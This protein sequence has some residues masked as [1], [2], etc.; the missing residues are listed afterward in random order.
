[1]MKKQVKT[2]QKNLDTCYIDKVYVYIPEL[3][4]ITKNSSRP[5]PRPVLSCPVP[6]CPA[7]RTFLSRPVLSR[8]IL[9]LKSRPVPLNSFFKVPSCPAPSSPVP[10]RLVPPSSY[11]ESCLVPFHYLISTK[12]FSSFL[13]IR[14]T[15]SNPYFLVQ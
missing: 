12:F 5:V 3:R 11:L 7:S 15:A 4:G 13:S 2:I 10:S 14:E 6:S 9:F 8:L 1:M